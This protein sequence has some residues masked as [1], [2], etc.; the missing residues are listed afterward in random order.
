MGSCFRCL[1]PTVVKNRG[2]GVGRLWLLL[3][4]LS[5][6][7]SGQVFNSSGVQLPPLK[8]QTQKYYLPRRVGAEVKGLMNPG[9]AEPGYAWQPVP[10]S[11]S[12]S[13]WILSVVMGNVE[14][15]NESLSI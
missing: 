9:V 7:I 4:L 11:S 3:V 14:C 13:L 12:L 6:A 2:T 10:F 8:Q 15:W 1:A 5:I